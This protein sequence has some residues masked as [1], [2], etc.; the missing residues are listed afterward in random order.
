MNSDSG[1]FKLGLFVVTGVALIV[2]G[3]VVFGAGALRQ[4]AVTFETAT[5]DSVDGLTVGAPVKYAGVTVGKVSAIEMTF[6]RHRD[7]SAEEIAKIR[8]YITVE[9]QIRRE[10]L[11]A[12]D[13]AELRKNLAIIVERGF[14]VRMASSGLTGPPFLELVYLS[15]EDNPI[16][17]LP[18]KP[19]ELF[20]PSAR[21]EMTEI[22]NS[23]EAITRQIKKANVEAI[24]ADLRKLINDTDHSLT[25]LNTPQL[26]AK[27]N[28]LT[29]ELHTT[30]KKVNEI[31]SGPPVTAFV[32]DLPKMS[33]QVRETLAKI[34]GIVGDP[35]LKNMID[36]LSKTADAAAPASED[37]RQVLRKLDA[38]VTARS[39][40][41][42]AI[43]TSLRQMLSDGTLLV[44]DAKTNPSRV[45]FG[46]PPPPVKIG[47]HK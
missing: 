6:W 27:I 35:K 31:L 10:M 28:A 14:R 41:I 47:D 34:D 11:P 4:D 8:R 46:D 40:D 26:S 39:D 3:I 9:M 16:T 21:S 38:M 19:S 42:A 18:F 20:I 33:T 24:V 13:E 22:V 37:L 17:E 36:E 45:L 2:A 43:A 1:F 25:A 12:K 29:D 30:T 5:T 15:P 23:V 32:G 7:A 44:E